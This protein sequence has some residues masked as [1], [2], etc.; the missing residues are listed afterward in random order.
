MPRV[1][2][3][4]TALVFLQMKHSTTNGIIVSLLI[5]WLK[6]KLTN[7]YRYE[8]YNNNKIENFIYSLANTITYEKLCT[9]P[10]THPHD[11]YYSLLNSNIENK[12]KHIPK[13]R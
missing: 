7:T 8:K 11:N 10:N 3:K 2:S 1:I 5:I 9:H 13:I 12:N 4:T 6:L